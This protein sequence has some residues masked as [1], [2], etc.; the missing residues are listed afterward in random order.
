MPP[1]DVHN[2]E[3]IAFINRFT[4]SLSGVLQFDPT[5]TKE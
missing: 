1:Q 3:F 5:F 4:Y 2:V